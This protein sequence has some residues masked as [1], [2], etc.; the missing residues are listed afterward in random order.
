MGVESVI[1]S[2][3]EPPRAAE[4][5]PAQGHGTEGMEQGSGLYS[6]ALHGPPHQ[7]VCP[8]NEAPFLVGTKVLSAYCGS[9]QHTC[10]GRCPRS[11]WW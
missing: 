10:W 11:W 1:P 4:G 8:G 9:A 5:H 7:C 3:A 2:T 6:T